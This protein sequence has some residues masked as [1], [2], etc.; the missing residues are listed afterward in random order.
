MKNQ[1][2]EKEIREIEEI[3]NNILRESSSQTCG[4]EY[5][6]WTYAMIKAKRIYN[7]TK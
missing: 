5:Q 2:I 6:K 7:K 4:T 1:E 3:A